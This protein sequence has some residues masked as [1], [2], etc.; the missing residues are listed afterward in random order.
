MLSARQSV[1][2]VVF[3]LPML[4]SSFC[5]PIDSPFALYFIQTGRI[6]VYLRVICIFPSTLFTLVEVQVTFILLK[7]VRDRQTNT[8]FNMG[9]EQYTSPSIANLHFYFMT[10]SLGLKACPVR[11]KRQLLLFTCLRW[12]F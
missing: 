5:L 8:R 10:P 7:Y 3:F 11:K 2:Y 1:N 9:T 6:S 12:L 4:C